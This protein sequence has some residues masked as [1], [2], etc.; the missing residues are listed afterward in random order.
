M[1]KVREQFLYI[2]EEARRLS[3]S[4]AAGEPASAVVVAAA[5]WARTRRARW[6]SR[7]QHQPSIELPGKR[8]ALAAAALLP[9][10][11]G[12]VGGEGGGGYVFG[13]GP[14]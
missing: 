10:G 11:K 4:A 9:V 1:A 13:A 12:A 3:T 14:G 8:Q 2:E 7:G 6:G 5:L